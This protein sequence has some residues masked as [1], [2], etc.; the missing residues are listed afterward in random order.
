MENL[1]HILIPKE[2]YHSQTEK[3]VC[4]RI[5]NK[6]VWLPKSQMRDFQLISDNYDFW[7][8]MWIIEQNK[9]EAFIDSSWMPSLFEMEK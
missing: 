1:T 9:L 8:P 6:F 3:A 4:F 2:K 5:N 7:M